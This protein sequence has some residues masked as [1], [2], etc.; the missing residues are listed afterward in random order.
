MYLLHRLCIPNCFNNNQFTIESGNPFN[1]TYTNETV[2]YSKFKRTDFFK[3]RLVTYEA[4]QLKLD[5]L[6]T[7]GN[8]NH[9]YS[10]YND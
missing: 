5:N 3:K 4:N 2:K 10:T 9:A 6:T 7:K 1:N 8:Q